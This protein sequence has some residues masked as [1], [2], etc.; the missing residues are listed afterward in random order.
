[1]TNLDHARQIQ[2]DSHRTLS[3]YVD[4]RCFSNIERLLWNRRW[5]G[6]LCRQHAPSVIES[7]ITFIASKESFNAPTCTTSLSVESYGGGNRNVLDLMCFLETELSDQLLGAYVHGSLGCGEEV[8]YSDFDVL[9]IF[10][11]SVFDS[12]D[13]L[14]NTAERAI[15][16]RR[17]LWNHDP[18]QHHG[19]LVLRE[20]DL[21]CYPDMLFPRVLF[22]HSRSLLRHGGRLRVVGTTRTSEMK[23]PLL[24]MLAS[25]ERRIERGKRPR[26]EFEL[27]VL[28]SQLLLL[29]CLIL[30]AVDRAVFKRESFLAASGLFEPQ[31]W[32]AIGTA[33]EIR[34]RWIRRVNRWP[35][36]R[37][38]FWAMIVHAKMGKR[39]AP[40][41][42]VLLNEEFYVDIQRFMS[43]IRRRL[44]A[45]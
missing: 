44:G 5:S 4:G 17:F 40:G 25:I 11:D 42:A 37:H 29:P 34:S 12:V 20:S 21:G 8:P 9:M 38:P 28:V 30:Q 14:A 32:R 43:A 35:W 31:D 2:V 23:R 33:S 15:D 7:H 16:A 45:R 3:R 10:R 24:A 36:R 26:S 27:K 39:I 6:I 18:L 22:E 13:S 19:F 41:I 1:M